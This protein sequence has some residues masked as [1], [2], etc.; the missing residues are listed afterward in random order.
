MLGGRARS[1][2]SGLSGSAARRIVDQSRTTVAR[3]FRSGPAS[4]GAHEPR[5]VAG[6]QRVART[7]GSASSEPEVQLPDLG[8]ATF[9]LSSHIRSA[10]T[11]QQRGIS[12]G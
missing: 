8:P 7:V 9:L 4:R 2:G 5:S 6:Q 1:S 12:V 10:R 3:L 11:R